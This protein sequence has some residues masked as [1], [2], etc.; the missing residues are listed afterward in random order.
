MAASARPEHTSKRTVSHAAMVASRYAR[1]YSA[2]VSN[3]AVRAMIGAAAARRYGETTE[4][5]LERR[6]VFL[7]GMNRLC[8]LFF[9]LLVTEITMPYRCLCQRYSAPYTQRIA[10]CHQIGSEL[11]LVQTIPITGCDRL[12]LNGRLNFLAGY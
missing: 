8:T 7:P 9:L 2:Y 12:S 3:N 10:P 4:A 11:I 1:D 6:H 5:E